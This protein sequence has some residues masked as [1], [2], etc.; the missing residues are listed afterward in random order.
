[1]SIHA[2]YLS[3]ALICILVLGCKAKSDLRL[4]RLNTNGSNAVSVAYRDEAGDGDWITNRCNGAKASALFEAF[5]FIG[6][7]E[8]HDY[9]KRLAIAHVYVATSDN[10]NIYIRVFNDGAFSLQ[11]LHYWPSGTN[12]T[13]LLKLISEL[14][15]VQ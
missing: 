3:Y 14:K 6:C 13:R 1:M 5:D 4:L 7:R 2:N 12:S 11:G 10:K 15:A 9:A 8:D